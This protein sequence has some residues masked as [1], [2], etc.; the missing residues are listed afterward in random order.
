MYSAQPPHYSYTYNPRD[1]AQKQ[2]SKAKIFH[3]AS[4]SKAKHADSISEAHNVRCARLLQR[5]THTKKGIQNRP[6]APHHQLTALPEA[7]DILIDITCPSTAPP[8]PSSTPSFPTAHH[9]NHY[10]NGKSRYLF[11]PPAYSM[12][13]RAALH[14]QRVNN[15]IDAQ[16]HHLCFV[17]L[18]AFSAAI[19]SFFSV[20]C[21]VLFLHSHA[22]CSCWA[23]SFGM[24]VAWSKRQ[25]IFSDTH[26]VAP[27]IIN[28]ITVSP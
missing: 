8:M 4:T 27:V 15:K 11:L 12:S 1:T 9:K 3:H 20:M 26:K 19:F 14:N 23:L 25:G 22:T 2:K 13:R 5:S 17:Y 16:Q 6:R 7:M 24:I 18:V 28:T 21:I 10:P